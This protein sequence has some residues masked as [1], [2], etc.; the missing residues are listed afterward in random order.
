[1]FKKVNSGRQNICPSSAEINTCSLSMIEREDVFL[2]YFWDKIKRAGRDWHNLLLWA[3]AI[4]IHYLV[5]VFFDIVARSVD[6]S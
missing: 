4:W 5:K 2:I 1:M 3:P 6:V